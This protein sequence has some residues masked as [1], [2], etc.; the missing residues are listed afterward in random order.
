MLCLRFC[1]PKCILS[2]KYL[3]SW[4]FLEFYELYPLIGITVLSKIMTNNEDYWFSPI[5]LLLVLSTIQT[6]QPA[7]LNPTT[8]SSLMLNSGA[9]RP[10]GQNRE[11]RNKPRHTRSISSGQRRQEH[12]MGTGQSLQAAVLKNRR[13]T[14]KR[15][16]TTVSHHTN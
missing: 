3:I 16:W 1:I 8:S 11:S 14:C 9:H 10:M 4:I 7:V 2:G 5:L 13:S 6:S 15:N 12:A